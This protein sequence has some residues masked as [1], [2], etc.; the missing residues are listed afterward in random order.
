MKFQLSP[1][2]AASG[3]QSQLAVIV[4]A[5]RTRYLERSLQS[6]VAQTD[7]RFNL[8]VFDDASPEPIESMVRKFQDR[9]PLSYHRFAENLGGRSLPQHWDRC[10][11]HISER[12]VW[13]FSDDDEMEPTCVEALW[14]E[15][16]TTDGGFDLYRFNS[17]C[18]D[19]QS[20]VIAVNEPYPVEEWGKDFLLVRLLEQRASYA[21]ELV[22]SR[23]AWKNAGGFPDYPM[24]WAAD[25]AFIAR[26]GKDK[27]IRLVP[28]PRILWR[29]SGTNIT[30][31]TSTAMLS[32]KIQASRMFIEWARQFLAGEG[33]GGKKFTCRELDAMTE[34]WFFRWLLFMR[35]RLSW[36]ICSEVDRFASEVWRHPRGYG[37]MKCLFWNS[38]M[39]LEAVGRRSRALWQGPPYFKPGQS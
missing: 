20:Q 28:G 5:F 36:Q 23:A 9:L 37:W 7:K 11:E 8:Y 2:G 17:R 22:F 30:S 10:V 32:R 6:I 1:D 39:I 12:W 33:S 16:V 35:T 14:R 18:I 13:L 15:I 24:A 29:Q 31:V 25:D 21:Q 27:P 34:T 38:R 26:M 19:K 4:P 3:H